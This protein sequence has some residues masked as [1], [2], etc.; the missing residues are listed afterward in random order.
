MHLVRGRAPDPVQDR[1][2]T[3]RLLENATEGVPGVRVWAPPRHVAFGRRD[4]RA[5]GYERARRA[6]ERAGF[7]PVERSVGGRA[8]AYSGE[9]LAFAVATPRDDRGDSIDDRYTTVGRVVQRALRDLGAVVA[10]GEPPASFCPGDHSV[11]VNEGGKLTGLAQRVR[12]DAALVAGCLVPTVADAAVL[13]RVLTPTYDALEVDF[14]PATV[15]SVEAAGGP[16]DT[17]TIQRAV[18]L[19]LCASMRAN[20]EHTEAQSARRS[21]ND[22]RADPLLNVDAATNTTVRELFPAI[23]VTRVADEPSGEGGRP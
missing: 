10:P 15:G 1:E 8:V 20:D 14:D 4:A 18:E 16:T 3:A 12:A 5:S 7:V 11:R 23:T 13:G 19:A 2:P 9:T 6:A 17:T 21:T 22:G